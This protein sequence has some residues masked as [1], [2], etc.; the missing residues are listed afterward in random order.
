MMSFYIEMFLLSPNHKNRDNYWVQEKWKC[1]KAEQD[2]LHQTLPLHFSY[3][4]LRQ[5]NS[6]CPKQIP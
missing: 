2:S 3:P 5:N 4:L 1:V 6:E